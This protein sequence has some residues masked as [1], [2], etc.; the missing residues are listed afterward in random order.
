MQYLGKVLAVIWPVLF[1][2]ALWL[3]VGLVALFY[4][5]ST[6][7]PIFLF[8]G[9]AALLLMVERLLSP[10][11]VVIR[12]LQGQH[13][14]G[15]TLGKLD[16][17]FGAYKYEWV[18]E[19]LAVIVLLV[20][21]I[22]EVRRARQRARRTQAAQTAGAGGM[23]EPA[24]GG[25]ILAGAYAQPFAAQPGASHNFGIAGNGDTR[26]ERPTAQT[27]SAEEPPPVY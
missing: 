16:L 24:G 12:Y 25:D 11:R 2:A 5:R 19:G 15:G 26:I 13:V 18:V 27:F 8:S 9:L 6:R 17:L 14:S 7:R 10:G 1:L 4:A 3:I 23:A 20:G 22:L 21:I